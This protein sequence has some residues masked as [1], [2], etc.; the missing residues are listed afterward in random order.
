MPRAVVWA[1]GNRGPMAGTSCL[2]TYSSILSTPCHRSG[3]ADTFPPI[4]WLA[5]P[6][7]SLH[8]LHLLLAPV[9][10][11][12]DLVELKWGAVHDP[13]ASPSRQ[14]VHTTDPPFPLT[15]RA[16]LIRLRWC[17]SDQA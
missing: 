15:M 13:G 14:C 5:G 17:P 16:R 8:L 9:P 12:G 11:D 3:A 4:S 2:I 7:G 1:V 6:P 10:R